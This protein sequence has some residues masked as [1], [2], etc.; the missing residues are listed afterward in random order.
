ME[1]VWKS[2]LWI[3]IFQTA[4][5]RARMLLTDNIQSGGT[6][7]ARDF[8]NAVSGF[9]QIFI[10]TRVKSTAFGQHRKFPPYA[11]KASGTQGRARTAVVSTITSVNID[12]CH[13][14]GISAAESQTWFLRAKRPQLRRARRNGCFRRLL[15]S[16]LTATTMKMNS[17]YSKPSP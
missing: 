13:Q 17:K 6:L 3:G 16:L 1:Y 14:Y 5:Q 12:L 9:C 4:T 7:D 15:T 11:R 10:V 2:S 8:S